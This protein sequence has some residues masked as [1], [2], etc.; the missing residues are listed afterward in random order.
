MAHAKDTELERIKSGCQIVK[1]TAEKK[2]LLINSK[3][4]FKTN[5]AVKIH[6]QNKNW[7]KSMNTSAKAS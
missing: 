3:Y 7:R 6:I 4:I 2:H 5:D 1:M